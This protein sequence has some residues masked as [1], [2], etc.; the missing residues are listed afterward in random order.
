MIEQVF[1]RPSAT[2]HVIS[3]RGA[4]HEDRKAVSKRIFW[5]I[6][7]HLEQLA[8]ADGGWSKLYRDDSD[9]R[10]WE[11]VHPDGNAHGGGAPELREINASQAAAKYGPDVV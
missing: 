1:S 11:L 3:S 8:S 5:Y 4:D 9:D 2:E 10:L 6:R 7:T